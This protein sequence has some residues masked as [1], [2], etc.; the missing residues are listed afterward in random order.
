MVI[1][2]L[3]HIK[4]SKMLLW[5]N[6]S[7]I[8]FKAINGI[9]NEIKNDIKEHKSSLLEIL[10]HNEI[11]SESDAK[12]L[13]YY[14]IPTNMRSNILSV[15]QQ[16]IYLQN[17]LDKQKNTYNVPVFVLLKNINTRLLEE[18]LF[19]LLK[20]HP[21]L[22]VCNISDEF[23]YEILDVDKFNV[24]TINAD[25]KDVED[26]CK[27][28]SEYEFNLNSG[29]LFNP[30]I[31][32][33]NGTNNAVLNLTHHHILSDGYST[34]F[35]IAEVFAAYSDIEKKRNFIG[36][37]INYFDYTNFQNY[38][39]QT[40]EYKEAIKYLANKLDTAE[41][42]QLKTSNF[43]IGN[44]QSSSF[45]IAINSNVYAKLQ[46]ISKQNKVSLYAILFT[47]LYH[48]LSS[49]VGGK[50]NFPIGTNISNRTFELNGVIGPCISTLALIPNY[51]PK[52]S[53]I[54]NIILVND[55]AL[56]L[57]EYHHVNLNVLAKNLTN[58]TGI[59]LE[60]LMRVMF[61]M[62]NI[63][64]NFFDLSKIQDL[65]IEYEIINKSEE[66]EKFG[67]SIDAIEQDTELSFNVNYAKNL[68]DDDYIKSIMHTF[69]TFLENINE[70]NLRHPIDQIA[71]LN[72]AEYQQMIGKLRNIEHQYSDNKTIHQL[73]EEQVSRTPDNVAIVYQ[74]IKL[75][76]QELN[77]KANRLAHYLI[78][79]YDIKPDTL[80]PLYLNRNE[81]MLVA[82]LAVLK[83]GAAYVPI[84]P[85]YPDIRTRY[86]LSDIKVKLILTNDIYN[87]KL[88]NIDNHMDVICIDSI[89]ML[90][91]LTKQSVFNLNT[92]INSR[93]LAYVIYTS[94]TT[95]EPKGV[96]I[97]HTGVVNLKHDLTNRYHL[98]QNEV[99]LQLA[100]YVF[101][102]SI[103]QI[104]LALCNGY[105]LLL[106]QED[107]W[108][109]KEEFYR[110]LNK[111][112]VTHLEA[113][114]TLL[115]QYDFSRI[116][117]LRRIVSGGEYFSKECYS[118]IAEC[119]IRSIINT[120]GPTETTINA[121]TNVMTNNNISIGTP[122]TNTKCYVLNK[123]LTLLPIGAI[124]ELHIGGIGLARG[125]LN[126][127]DL[128]AEKFI[129]N[130]F[131]DDSRLYKTGD[132]VRWTSDYNLEYIG[133]DDCQ[134][135]IRGYRIE[136][137]EI[138]SILSLYTGIQQ[139]A[140]CLKKQANG[141]S[142][143]IGYYV[144]ND[145]L[146]KENILNYLKDKLPEYMVPSIIMQINSLPITVNGKLDIDALPV[147]EF[148]NLDNCIVP[149]NELESKISNI[150]LQV[151]S[152]PENTLSIDADFFR[153]GG[154]S[155]LAMKLV[156]LLNN[157]FI[158]NK[159]LNIKDLY[160][161]ST[162]AKL[163][164]FIINNSMLLEE[165]LIYEK[166][167][168]LDQS[169]TPITISKD[170]KINNKYNIFITG[171]TGFIGSYL[172]K[173]LMENNLVD[174]IFCLVVADA[175]DEAMSKISNA[176]DYY[177]LGNCN[178]KIIPVVGTLSEKYFGLTIE[179]FDKITDDV[180]VVI[181]NA[182]FMNH[183]A[184]YHTIKQVNVQG[185]EEILRFACTKRQ[186]TVNVISTI[187]VFNG[188]S[189]NKIYDED[190]TIRNEQHYYSDG[191][192]ASKWVAEGLCNI[193]RQRGVNCNIYRLS[194]VLPHSL[195]P[196][197]PKY[198]WFGRFI[199][200]CLDFGTFP[201]ELKEFETQIAC[202]DEVTEV[203][204]CSSLYASDRNRNLHLF[205]QDALS[206]ANIFTRMQILFNCKGVKLDDWL[207]KYQSAKLAHNIPVIS[208]V[209]DVTALKEMISN[210]F[211]YLSEKTHNVIKKYNIHFSKFDDVYIDSLLNQAKVTIF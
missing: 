130:P 102:A 69:K 16:G 78:E 15:I 128:T 25:I 70:K 161:N 185:M 6:G 65:G 124:G 137:K 172:L 62:Y 22:R 44:Y 182:T 176:L 181:H 197:Y 53:L 148:S 32:S 207:N 54:E 131:H 71:L 178:D 118:K 3:Y 162:I 40:R 155:I 91:E 191:Y 151:L 183:L 88:T 171:V 26:L 79:N 84:D 175:K 110:Y 166:E 158:S 179:E 119:K 95:G 149:R 94:G 112:N 8:V 205:S 186:K 7:D 105:T 114:P 87:E 56:Y 187:N 165:K 45:K 99:I 51:D 160:V 154:N 157:Q 63:K 180:D 150:W 211:Q 199:K 195:K 89:I 170:Y 76:Y 31:I 50:K 60:E 202:V 143:L 188:N 47:S 173:A 144:S 34:D 33:I 209:E 129:A 138:E 97:E 159:H 145:K 36:E 21:I 24:S 133:R 116:P 146:D 192:S 18:A 39:L 49:Y 204:I 174:K 142:Y 121:V 41:L 83:S 61:T 189:L 153:L 85:H 52:S 74:D 104:I 115:E 92:K 12:N 106:I 108:S 64:Q 132:L 122:I 86:I 68:Y 169:I 126:K 37:Q 111:N 90:Q 11:N 201:I 72:K 200:A 75:T 59:K 58:N 14:K 193:A 29:Q 9:S 96:M 141:E 184:T 81:H 23:S 101:D 46:I 13:L 100:N 93:N 27:Q 80:I 20:K 17:K 123:S 147:P 48:V 5:R 82:I 163:S 167:V 4:K 135:K 57:H 107:L 113:T 1:D 206:F 136:L 134:V 67:I 30:E 103:E 177:N 28:R 156:N 198:Q 208:I 38:N 194:L 55:E 98:Q 127:P 42:L 152:I 196:I 168:V 140:V 139:T 125:Y 43:N 19:V 109:N 117:S 10:T 2:L 210:N 120:Y 66:I 73:F 190:T 77:T 164:A 203:V 35:I